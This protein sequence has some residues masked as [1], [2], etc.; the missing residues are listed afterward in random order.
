[1]LSHRVLVGDRLCATATTVRR[2]LGEEGPS[3]LVAAIA[4]A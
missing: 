1:L 3:S 2:V 4:G